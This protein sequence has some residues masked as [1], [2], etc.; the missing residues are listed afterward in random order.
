V[1]TTAGGRRVVLSRDRS[2]GRFC[3]GKGIDRKGKGREASTQKAAWEEKVTKQ[4][5]LYY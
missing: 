1:T 2:V 3:E 5:T 4:N